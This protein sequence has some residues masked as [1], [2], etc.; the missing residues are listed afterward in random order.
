MPIEVPGLWEAAGHGTLDGVAWYRRTFELDETAGRWTLAF[1][2][3]MDE[4][5]VFL[6]GVRVGDHA[7]PFTP[8]TF[9]VS[10]ILR[11]ADNVLAVRVVDY[12]GSDERHGMTAHGKQGWMNDV[13]PSPPSL[14]LHYG[15]IWQSVHLER[16][17]DAR[18]ESAWINSNPD[19][20]IV[21][22]EVRG[23]QGTAARV[24]L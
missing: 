18:I 11:A 8:F 14:Y 10:D 20:L 24:E 13:F 19:D 21:E 16:H 4:A 7:G 6:N 22:V 12:A 5:E 2:A 3:V 1:G 9:D 23:V 15:G 17:G